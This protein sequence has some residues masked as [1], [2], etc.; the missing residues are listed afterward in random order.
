L[1]SLGIISGAIVSHLTRLGIVVENDGGLLFALAV[2]VFACSL[3]ILVL[4]RQQIPI[5]SRLFLPAAPNYA[6]TTCQH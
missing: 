4:R 3:A 2:I 5:L 6:A 1:L